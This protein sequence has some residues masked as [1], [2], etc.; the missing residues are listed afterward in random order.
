MR[1]VAI[2][3][4]ILLVC[5]YTSAYGESTPLSPP[6]IPA[7]DS[8]DSQNNDKEYEYSSY[9]L[10]DFLF[11]ERFYYPKAFDKKLNTTTSGGAFSKLSILGN[12]LPLIL[13]H[14]SILPLILANSPLVVLVKTSRNFLEQNFA[15][16][17]ALVGKILIDL[18]L[19]VI[20]ILHFS[21]FVG[22]KF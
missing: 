18:V 17:M 6:N 9:G 21:I 13:I 7:L 8:E 5:F 15:M 2:I 10:G 1:R 4:Q 12:T 14:K 11:D 19:R 20:G 16:N 3:G 22:G